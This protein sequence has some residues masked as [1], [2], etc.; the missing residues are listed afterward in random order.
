MVL[1]FNIPS[2]QRNNLIRTVI[3]AYFFFW[4]KILIVCGIFC[5]SWMHLTLGCLVIVLQYKARNSVRRLT[6]WEHRALA[7]KNQGYGVHYALYIDAYYEVLIPFKISL[8]TIFAFSYCL[9][10]SLISCFPIFMSRKQNV[11]VAS[12]LIAFV[13]AGLAFPFYMASRSSKATPV[14]D[15]S[16]PLPPQ[17]TFRGPYINTGS[18]DIGPDQQIYSKKQ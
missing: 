17:A 10:D 2:R 16:K 14:I 15:S 13:A 11:V 18:Q 8:K 7:L 1:E 3:C 12:G 5:T 9:A 4:P 6:P